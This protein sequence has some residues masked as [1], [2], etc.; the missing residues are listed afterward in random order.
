MYLFTDRCESDCRAA[1]RPNENGLIDNSR[2]ASV[3]IDGSQIKQTWS[4]GVNFLN[5]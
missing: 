1:L 5:D 3:L 2:A 4:A